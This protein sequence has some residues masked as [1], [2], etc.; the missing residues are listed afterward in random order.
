MSKSFA[1]DAAAVENYGYKQE[2]KRSLT[3]V[4]LIIYGLVFMLPIAPWAVFGVVYNESRGMVPLIYLLGV[5]AMIF[6]ALSYAQMSR[7]VPLAGGVFSYVTAGINP[8]VGFFAGWLM[9]LDYLLVPT[10]L[11][12]FGAESMVGLFP[13]TERW[14]WGIIFVVVNTIINL[15]GVTSLKNLNRIFVS[16]QLFFI[17]AFVVIAVGAISSGASPDIGWSFDPMWDASKVTAPLLAGALSLAVL[18][19]LGFDGIAM[20]SEESSGGRKS[21]GRAMVLALIVMATLFITQTWLASLLA[22]GVDQF[23]ADEANNAFFTIV[24]AVAGSG[25]AQAFLVVN[26]FAVGIAN[27]MAGQAAT[28]RLLYSMARDGRL[29]SFLS[30]V[31][32]K[33]VPANALIAVAILTAVLVT[34][35]VGQI[36]LITSLVTIGALLGFL[37][38]HFTVIWALFIKTSEHRSVLNHLLFPGIG[39]LIIGYV[40]INAGTEAQIGGVAWLVVGI[41]VYFVT[42][43]RVRGMSAGGAGSLGQSAMAAETVRSEV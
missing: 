17:V 33:Q 32:R 31:S 8:T 42:R 25:W 21:G 34:F 1:N 28:S 18:S 27:A 39:F 4:D 11:Y 24:A 29:P 22:G 12:V 14:M 13:E 6:T 15:M 26:A 41:I 30:K 10:L 37:M 16:I 20:M 3:A 2:L 40:V 19:F 35:F 23:S 9:L 43:G 5:V 38:L 36:E 7:R